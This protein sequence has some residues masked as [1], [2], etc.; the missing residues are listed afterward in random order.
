MH[1]ETETARIFADVTSRLLGHGYIDILA[2]CQWPKSIEHLPSWVPD[3]EA[4]SEPCLQTKADIIPSASRDFDPAWTVVPKEPFCLMISGTKVDEIRGMGN[5]W[6]PDS[7][8]DP[9]VLATADR[10]FI[11]KQLYEYLKSVSLFSEFAK[12]EYKGLVPITADQWKEAEWRVPCGDQLWFGNRRERAT[13]AGLDGYSALLKEIF[14]YQLIISHELR[15]QQNLP[16]LIPG[17]SLDEQI[18]EYP[19]LLRSE[20]RRQYRDALDRQHNRR[21]FVSQQGYIGLAPAHAKEGDLVVILFGAVQPFVLRRRGQRY[22]LV[23]K[24]YV[25]GIMDGEFLKTSPKRKDFG[26]V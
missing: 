6:M 25:Y 21:P 1:S 22:E 12:S 17:F 10:A 11:N 5:P 18:G 8:A 2:W 16:A 20:E 13:N 24:A 19:G 7:T 26:L 15:E 4:I 14:L 23:G 3:F 9:M